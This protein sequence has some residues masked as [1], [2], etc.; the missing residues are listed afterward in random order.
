MKQRRIRL[1]ELGFHD[2]FSLYLEFT[3]NLVQSFHVG[4]ENGAE[5]EVVRSRSLAII[6]AALTCQASLVHITGHGRFEDGDATLSTEDGDDYSLSELAGELQAESTPIAT[7]ALL[8]DAC[9]SASTGFQRRL[10][11]C[12]AKPT[13]LIGSSRS[14]DWSQST[15]W[16]AAFYSAFLRG[17]GKG[18]EPID[19]AD[20]ALRRANEAYSAVTDRPSPYRSVTLTPTRAASSAFAKVRR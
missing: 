6:D 5:V 17:K 15:V 12:I 14:L 16:T 9:S 20:D 1:V 7:S 10:R 13:L 18:W 4:T 11:D 8:I 19:W 3:R 2:D